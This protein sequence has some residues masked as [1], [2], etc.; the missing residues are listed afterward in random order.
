M[1]NYLNKTEIK[2]VDGFS[3][4]KTLMEVLGDKRKEELKSADVGLWIKSATN[5]IEESSRH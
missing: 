2:N 5:L 4:I 1:W 3:A